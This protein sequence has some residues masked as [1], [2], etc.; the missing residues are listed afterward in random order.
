MLRINLIVSSVCSFVLFLNEILAYFFFH[1]KNQ[2]GHI[3]KNK[4]RKQQCELS[5]TLSE[6]VVFYDLSV[7]VAVC[8]SVHMY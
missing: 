1:P 5:F 7:R 4:P 2:L 3:F 8:C 6:S